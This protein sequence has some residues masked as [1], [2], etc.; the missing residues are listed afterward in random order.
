MCYRRLF[1]AFFN[2]KTHLFEEYCTSLAEKNKKTYRT[3]LTW[4]LFN[5]LPICKN[6]RLCG[7]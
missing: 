7:N 5:L 1:C 3:A 2:Y 6:T 4:N